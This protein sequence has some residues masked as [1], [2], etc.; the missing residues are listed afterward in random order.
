MP[1][2]SAANSGKIIAGEMV[3]ALTVCVGKGSKQEHPLW[4]GIE[5]QGG[6]TMLSIWIDYTKRKPTAKGGS[7]A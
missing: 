4:F 7:P 2:R 1:A 3:R 5:S 6:D